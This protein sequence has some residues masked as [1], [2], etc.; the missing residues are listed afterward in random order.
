L[1]TTNL[2]THGLHVS[3]DGKSDNVFQTVG[4]NGGDFTFVY[5]IGASH[6][7]GTFWY[8]PHKHGSVAY[9]LSNGVSGALIVEGDPGDSIAD[10]EDLPEIFEASKPEH[11]QVLLV[12]L[13]TYLV[14]A[15]GI[16]RIDASQIYNVYDKSKDPKGAQSINVTGADP[17]DPPVQ[18]TAINGLINPT[19]TIAP[20]EVQR[21]RIVHAGWDLLRQL[22]WVDEN[23]QP[24]QDVQFYE[25]AIDGLA[26]GTM[27]TQSPLQIAPGQRSDVLIQGPRLVAGATQAIYHLK[28]VPTPNPLATH[29]TATDPYYL[30]KLVVG[31][32]QQNMNLPDVTNADVQKKLLACRPFAPIE[33]AD[34][35]T[36]TIPGGSGTLQFLGSDAVK[37]YTINGQTFHQSPP[38]EIPIGT[39][40]EWTLTAL[41]GSH[42]F[43][44]HVNPFQVVSYTSPSGFTVPM[45]VWRDTLYIPEGT[46]YTIRSRFR[47][48]VGDSVLHCHILDHED[49]GMMMVLRFVDRKNPTNLPTG[50]GSLKPTL[51]T[52][53]M[54]AP[55][56]KLAEADGP[57]RDLAQFR[58][59]PIVLVFF[60]GVDCFHCATQLRD[61][62][63]S[64]RRA[65]LE[66]EIMAVSSRPIAN[67]TESLEALGVSQADRFH[68]FVDDAHKAF[69]K[70]GCCTADQPR[71][72]TFLID[73]SGVIRA[74]YIGESPFDDP[75]TIIHRVRGFISPQRVDRLRGESSD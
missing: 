29:A 13:Y 53:S 30:A 5:N 43:H 2:H 46:S 37:N 38:I 66:F 12:Q 47:D 72:G 41:T 19:L 48:F 26:T 35:S 39:C 54:P 63:R 52:T 21:W 1:G 6:P 25:I 74:S 28:Q 32:T 60:K 20:G 23:D 59:R 65:D 27:S 62:V 4:P 45:N 68:L 22:I 34:L 73:Q 69:R 75:A 64:A 40:Q 17:A 33:D 56:L 42:P 61:L 58:G 57:M 15:N 67:P 10:L 36:A 9:Q 71:H 11:E 16:G 8:H 3:P 7:A 24:T 70:F 18:I 55:P 51:T 31:G 14:D 49:Q 50:P 44:I